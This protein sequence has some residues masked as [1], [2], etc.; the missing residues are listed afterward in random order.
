M[1]MLLIVYNQKI[2]EEVSLPNVYHADYDAVFDRGRYE[3]TE[4]LSLH[5]E[6]RVE[7]W[8]LCAKNGYEV[9]YGHQREAQHL[10]KDGD[11]ISILA[12]RDVLYLMVCDEAKCFSV[13]KKYDLSSCSRIPFGRDETNAV[14]YDFH[15]LI[16]SVHGVLQ[17]AGEDWYLTDCST[18]GIFLN[19]KRIRSSR[20]LEY[21]D[22]IHVFGLHMVFMGNILL[23][24]ADCGSLRVHGLPEVRIGEVSRTENGK[25]RNV[26]YFNRSPR[27]FPEL[28]QDDIV[29]EEPPVPQPS[30]QKPAYMV[31]GPAFTMAIPMCLGFVMAAVASQLNGGVSG[32]FMYTGLFTAIGSA[33]IGALWA[34]LNLN[35]SRKEAIES[36]TRRF[37]AYS[38]YLIGVTDQI[39][40]AFQTNTA[41]LNELYPGIR[42]VL[43][44]G[45]SSSGLWNRNNAHSD[46][47][48]ARIGTGDQPF[49]AEIRVPKKHF[50]LISDSLAEK[51]AQIRKEFS[52]LHQ[53]P[54]CVDL[55]HHPLLGVVGNSTFNHGMMRILSIQLAAVHCY[56]DVKFVYLY[57]EEK[58]DWSAVRWFPHVWSQDR[59]TRYVAGSEAERREILSDLNSLFQTRAEQKEISRN[60]PHFVLF[61]SDP[62]LLS[63]EPAAKYILHPERMLGITAVLFAESAS[64]LPNECTYFLMHTAGG[65]VLSET[66]G[67]QTVLTS[68]QPDSA[69]NDQLERFAVRLSNIQVKETE[70]TLEIPPSLTFFEMYG[71]RRLEEFDAA[72]RWR[73]SR[74]YESLRVPIGKKAGGADCCLDIHEKYHGPHGLVAG[75]T[76]SG[77]SELLQTY[78]LSL[79]LN[80]SPED[81]SFFLI[82]FKG[83][84]MANLFRDLPHTAGVISNLSGNQIQRAMI[85]IKSENTRRQKIF[86]RYGVNHISLYTKLYR[87]RKASERVPHLF[88]IIDEFAELKREESG[89]MSELISVAQ[90]GRSLGV[91]LILATQRPN[92]TVDDNIRSN[93]R[94]RLC[95]RVQDRQD[96][97][98]M[99]HKPDAA[100]LARAGRG[101]L[102]VGNDE[103]YEQFQA[104]YSGA[105][106]APDE[107]EAY[108]VELISR[109]G[110]PLV[111]PSRTNTEDIAG[112][113]ITQL[114]AVVQY[115]K[116]TAEENGYGKSPQLW[117]PVLP[118]SILWSDLV[119][120][121]DADYLHAW[122]AREEKEIAVEAG[123]YD[124]PHHQLQ[125]PLVLNFSETG[126]LAVCGMAVSGKSTFLQT[127]IYALMM[128]YSPQEVQMYILD[129]SGHRLAPFEKAPHTGGYMDDETEERTDKFFHF[130]GGIL[131]ERKNLLRGG[132]YAQYRGADGKRLPAL[133]VI[134]DNYDGFREK[135]SDRFE[136][137]ILRLCR[138]GISR[139]IYAVISASGFGISAIPMRIADNFRT[140]I[141]LEQQDKYKY[142]D[143]LRIAHLDL[144]PEKNIH[145]R[146]LAMVNGD[147]L[148]FQTA[149]ALEKDDDFHRSELLEDLSQQ[150]MMN[151]HGKCARRIPEIPEN[152]CWNVFHDEEMYAEVLKQDGMYPFAYSREDASVYAMNARTNYCYIL[153]GRKG[154]GKTNAMKALLR[155]AA[156]KGAEITVIEKNS[157]CQ[158][159]RKTALQLQAEY[160]ETGS[161]LYE[162]LQKLIPE[163][164]RRNQ[165]KNRMIEDGMDDA[166]VAEEMLKERPILIFADSMKDFMELVYHPEEGVGRM[167]GFV[168]NISERGQLHNILFVIGLNQ[169]D[170]SALMTYRSY[171]NFVSYH[172]GVYLGGSMT[173]QKIF[174][175]RNIPASVQARALK[176]GEAY[177]SNDREE[178]SG[179]PIVIPLVRGDL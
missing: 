118:K 92:G 113:E 159:L 4:S 160:I 11:I 35:Y 79:A 36:E 85:S 148:E 2:C 38:N 37:N 142:M 169:E 63:D 175:F 104:A 121:H 18:N 72:G 101:Y 58:E 31:I 9:Q 135:T 178:E 146:G 97:M 46:F 8:F 103:V 32:V 45:P 59:A 163:F 173:M 62:S 70:S 76:G 78:I 67:D 3:L 43:E 19:H 50:S 124:D 80:F 155:S 17:C 129:Y 10:L 117:L 83:A 23:L 30:A 164:R 55:Y 90:V 29:I 7:G 162:Y 84:G 15:G 99:L 44:Y 74:T 49:Q 114:D 14:C 171:N 143:V 26:R 22:S 41:A 66:E 54:I 126:H 128:K 149:C 115:L 154:T 16:S 170:C 120:G 12:G 152:P 40:R 33:G 107:T 69:D 13:M 88:I 87:Q 177:A 5:F 166:K 94:F 157:G 102:Q 64:Q 151:W 167:N 93:S 125:K 96:S 68:F 136:D 172:T 48:W 122:Q 137:V 176:K 27:Y 52:T 127:M 156:E 21:G 75:T 179:I 112:K 110:K 134:L 89:F 141:S 140:V 174:F 95:L 108:S 138:E 145:G 165:K 144:L 61:V 71:V 51:P 123:M 47:L 24:H 77:K 28:F 139:G 86:A 150:M 116:K 73:R 133:F 168:E 56:T 1:V 132:S 153:L 105:I 53:V 60:L 130:L 42:T 91:H 34:V 131:D 57:R 111:I 158:R 109:I 98:D 119:S 6:N 65:S 100:F 20:K 39:R 147:V 81:V 82:D 161:Q 106:Y 25:V